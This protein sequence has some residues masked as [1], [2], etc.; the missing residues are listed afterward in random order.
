VR[1]ANG[2]QFAFSNTSRYTFADRELQDED[3]HQVVYIQSADAE[4][5]QERV[6][7]TIDGFA[8]LNTPTGPNW[9]LAFLD[10]SGA[11]DGHTFVCRL[12]FADLD[13]IEFGAGADPALIRAFFYLASQAEALAAARRAPQR[14]IAAIFD[15]PAVTNVQI[16]QTFLGGASQGTRFMGGLL[17]NVAPLPA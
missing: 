13:Q 12:D 4:D 11:G 15:E 1:T 10:L 5:M 9:V 2:S 17:V 14:E 6:Q 8:A 3:V 7:R 16:I